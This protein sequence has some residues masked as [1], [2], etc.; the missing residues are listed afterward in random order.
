MQEGKTG[1]IELKSTADSDDDEAVCDDPEIVKLM[2]GYFYHLDYLHRVETAEED[3]IT[4]D[5]DTATPPPKKKAKK[6]ATTKTTRSRRVLAS[7]THRS[8]P[9]LPL[10][11]ST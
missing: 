5:E 1:T 4:I 6:S 2:V 3:I 10:Q 7:Q 9:N 8:R 11:K